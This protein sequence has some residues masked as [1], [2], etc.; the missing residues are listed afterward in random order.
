[1]DFKGEVIGDK[2]EHNERSGGKIAE[3]KEFK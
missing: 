3:I 2:E 1:M